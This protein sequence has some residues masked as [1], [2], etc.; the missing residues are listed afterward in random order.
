MIKPQLGNQINKNQNQILLSTKLK[1]Q[2]R[3]IQSKPNLMTYHMKSTNLLQ[4][5][6]LGFQPD[7]AKIE[8]KLLKRET[9]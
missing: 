3:I 6:K 7:M 5:L 8:L 1:L 4:S 2:N 9:I